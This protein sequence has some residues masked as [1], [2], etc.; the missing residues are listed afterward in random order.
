MTTQKLCSRILSVTRNQENLIRFIADYRVKYGTSPTLQE[1][2]KGIGV[3]DH[4]SVSGIISALVKQG[5]LERGRQ[6]IRSILLTDK[7]LEFL[8][9][10]LFRR[11]QLEEFSYSYRQTSPVSSGA[12][13]SPALDYVGHGEQSIKTDGTNLANDLRMLV[14]NTV[15][16]IATQITKNEEMGVIFG[17]A[18]L[19][20]GLTWA[21]T[22]I[23]GNGTNALVYSAIEAMVIKNFLSK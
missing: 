21:N 18:L 10:S 1:M 15:A 19:L 14:G 13:T 2:V 22:V 4:K 12:V 6:K 17:W 8:D 7:T 9:I 20:T 23:I 16:S 5:Y 11:Q 3:F